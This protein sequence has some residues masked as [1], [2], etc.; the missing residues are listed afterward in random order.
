MNEN[1]PI[2]FKE[3]VFIGAL[4]KEDAGMHTYIILYMKL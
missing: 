4:R 3:G 1:K 2:L